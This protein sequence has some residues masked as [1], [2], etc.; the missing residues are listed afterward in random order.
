MSLIWT[1]IQ[2]DRNTQCLLKYG[3]NF[4]VMI[5]ETNILMQFKMG[6]IPPLVLNDEFIDITNLWKKVTKKI[7]QSISENP[8]LNRFVH[9]NI[10]RY[11]ASS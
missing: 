10:S 4:D 7:Y 11:V 3:S 5:D 9:I 2:A 1:D 6:L 8:E